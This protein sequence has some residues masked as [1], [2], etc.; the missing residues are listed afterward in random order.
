MAD[1]KGGNRLKNNEI[2]DRAKKYGVAFWQI[3]DELGIA[4]NTFSTWLRY[5][6]SNEKR[7]RVMAAIDAIIAR[8]QG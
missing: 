7:E 2:R 4:A 6:L 8:R 5:E 3:A 1:K